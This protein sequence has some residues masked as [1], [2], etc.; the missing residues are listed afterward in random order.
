MVGQLGGLAAHKGAIAIGG[1]LL[2]GLV[3]GTAFVAAGALAPQPTPSPERLTAVYACPGDGP[4][5]DEVAPGQI[6]LVT[7]RSADSEW[8]EVYLAAPGLD[9]AWT[10]A[11]GLDLEEP[12]DGLP[13]GACDA[14]AIAAVPQVLPTP[15]PVPTATP[16]PEATPSPSESA[17]PAPT[18]TP[19]PRPKPTPTPKPGATPTSAPTPSPSP[20]PT[21]TPTTSPSPSPSAPPDLTGPAVSNLGASPTAIYYGTCGPPWDSQVTVS[22]SDPSGVVQVRLYYTMPGLSEQWTDMTLSSGSATSGQ[23]AG[24]ITTPLS[25]ADGQI[26]YHVLAVDS[27]SNGTEPPGNSDISVTDCGGF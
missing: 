13:I 24:T 22:A 14:P 27:L 11:D 9:R 12:V 3:A 21:P 6:L 16:E 17:T 15:T 7:A 2:S 23:W 4:V 26:A 1:G 10:P 18:P 8:L 19:T 5:I 20:V 25:G